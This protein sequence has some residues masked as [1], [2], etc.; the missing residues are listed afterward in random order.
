MSQNAPQKA[1]SDAKLRVLLVEDDED[2]Y[3]LTRSMLTE[4]RSGDFQLDWVS[5]FDEALRAADPNCYDVCLL[6]YRLGAH[7]GVQLLKELRA[8]GFSCPMILLTGQGDKEIDNLAMNAGASDYLVKG[9]MNADNLERSIRYAI[10][11][12]LFQ[13]ERVN[14]TRAEEARLQAEAANKAK[15]EFLA[16]LSHELRTPLNAML[17]WIRLL[18]TEKDDAE[19]YER[20]IEAIER[21]A[22][23]QTK[24]IEDLL[25]VTRIVNG[26]LNLERAEVDLKAVIDQSIDATR[27][28]MGAK[29]ITLEK[30]VKAPKE[31]VV[32]D[33]VRLQQV[34]NNLISNAV[35]FTPEAGTITISLESVDGHAQI[36]VADTGDG[37]DKQF[38]PQV[39]DRY[40]QANTLTTNRKGGLGLGLA[41]VKK[42]V[43][44][45]GGT[46]TAESEGLGK[47][48]TFIVR[49]PYSSS[50]P[51]GQDV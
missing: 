6:D 32:G 14:H 22:L 11:Q 28:S 3:I 29:S 30:D 20:A 46:V 33:A 39:F 37:I 15:D 41:I 16:V 23:L 40:R 8:R 10:Q 4:I 7:D 25:D 13:D 24:F 47:G 50:E 19:V 36:K 12:K 48:A 5:D 43:E 21:N 45:H 9:T 51:K 26:T 44:M 1:E 31:A 49:L 18:K 17:G 42:I 38:L 2:D 35:K 34:L 27:P